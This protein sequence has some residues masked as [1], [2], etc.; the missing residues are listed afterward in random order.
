VDLVAL[1]DAVEPTTPQK[2][3]F[4]ARQRLAR[5][6]RRWRRDNG[7]TR[8]ES[9]P[10]T[11]TTPKPPRDRSEPRASRLLNSALET[12]FSAGRM[13]RYEVMSRASA[14]SVSLRFRLLREVLNRGWT[15]PSEVRALK[16]REIYT[17]IRDSYAPSAAQIKLALLVKATAIGEGD[18]AVRAQFDDP[19]LGWGRLV[20]GNLLAV[21][22]RGGH[23]SMLQEPWVEEVVELLTKSLQ[24]SVPEPITEQPPR[25][26]D[27]VTRDD[28]IYVQVSHG[29][30]Q[31]Q[32]SPFAT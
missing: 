8:A 19:L 7:A 29:A 6:A 12:T 16:V 10:P 4:V 27:L 26:R 15:W 22:T 32:K 17:C 1:L 5:L 23:S 2:R 25:S 21:D 24:P 3:F 28:A 14:V 20:D 18:D 13:L 11:S 9:R 31:T 30:R